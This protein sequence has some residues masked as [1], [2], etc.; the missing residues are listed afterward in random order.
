MK[1]RIL[2]FEELIAPLSKGKLMLVVECLNIEGCDQPEIMAELSEVLSLGY[3]EDFDDWEDFLDFGFVVVEEENRPDYVAEA[4]LLIDYLKNEKF[5][6]LIQADLFIDGILTASSWN[7][8]PEV[9]N[10]AESVE[11]PKNS[12]IIR[13]P[14]ERISRRQEP[15]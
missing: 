3:G 12:V 14:L 5:Q 10:I 8:E 7:G 2:S 4:H 6:P 15:K 1:H 11:K 9:W 13:F